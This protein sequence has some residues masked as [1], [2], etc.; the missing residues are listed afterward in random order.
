[1]KPVALLFVLSMLA[2]PA[3]AQTPTTPAAKT[4]AAPKAAPVS[5][6]ETPL[7]IEADKA[8]VWN[9]KAQQYI[10][11]GNALARQGDMQVQADTL[12]AD[13]RES[14]GRTEVW[15]LT[16]T[17]NVRLTG[18][19]ATGTGDK[20][21]Y[22]VGTGKAM[23]TGQNLKLTAEDG[24]TIT[25]D[26]HFEYWSNERKAMAVGGAVLTQKDTTL[27]SETITAW[28][29]ADS[30][31]PQSGAKPANAPAA[32]NGIDKAEATGGVT[33]K[34][35]TETVTAKRGSYDGLKQIAYLYDD[36]VLTRPPH[37]LNGARGEVNLATGISQLFAA[38]D[39]DGTPG[40][41]RGIFYPG[42]N[43]PLKKN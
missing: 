39:S 14:N 8:L 19:K 5:D 36:V 38:N 18:G 3:M 25:A 11:E 26:D 12:T 20:L 24:S 40:R 31:T 23:L 37:H 1:M 15:Q 10:A 27:S 41:V 16:A 35:A 13:Y 42:K 34:T 9:Q 4:A 30:A 22:D 6:S 2:I 33:I 21:T 7:E 32:G 29:S 43:S 17:G 28:L